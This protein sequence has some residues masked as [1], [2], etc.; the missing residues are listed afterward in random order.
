M[1]F[2]THSW[3]RQSLQQQGILGRR[4]AT[5]TR[6][7][8]PS[9]LPQIGLCQPYQ[10]CEGARAQFREFLAAP[11]ALA[12]RVQS[13]SATTTMLSMWHRMQRCELLLPLRRNPTRLRCRPHATARPLDVDLLAG[14]GNGF[15]AFAQQEQRLLSAL[16]TQQGH[17]RL[18]LRASCLSRKGWLI[19]LTKHQ[20]LC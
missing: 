7:G 12:L 3:L 10:S 6:Q 5:T 4:R 20:R 19:L 17:P 1:P 8:M 18:Q 14:A 2:A 9:I 13:G 15:V 11:M 16:P